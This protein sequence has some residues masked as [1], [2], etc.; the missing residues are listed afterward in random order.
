LAEKGAQCGLIRKDVRLSGRIPTNTILRGVIMNFQSIEEIVN[1]AVEK[2]EEAVAF[3]TEISKKETF[4]GAKQTFE[5]FAQEEKKHVTLLQGFSANKEK[6]AD[7]QYEWIPDMKRSDYMVDI[8]YEPGMHYTEILRLAM[9]REEQAL[10]L[11]NELA[12][13]TEN[14]DFIKLFQLLA[15]EEAKHKRVLET[16]YDDFMAKQGD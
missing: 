7:Y 11:Y 2:E 14:D 1:Y 8:E 16:I 15:Q 5:E 9:K 6:L 13:K 12:G 4:S 3:Y 10:K